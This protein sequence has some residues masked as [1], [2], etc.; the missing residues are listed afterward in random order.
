MRS[1]GGWSEVRS[2]R[3]AGIFQKSDERIL[4]DGDFV[5]TVLAEARQSINKKYALA[6][7]GITF[8]HVM[9]LVSDLLSV[10]PDELF[11]PGKN[12]TVVKGRS[13]LCFWLLR[14][15]GLSMTDIA[16]RLKIA[17]PTVS[18]SVKK[19][20]QIA[21]EEGLDLPRLLNIKI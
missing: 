19:G 4:G 15:L 9:L 20:E 10:K 16:E 13:L 14:E 1:A 2:L 5:R 11:G 12:R 7:E 21:S 3:K 6:A 8:E 18:V 17:V